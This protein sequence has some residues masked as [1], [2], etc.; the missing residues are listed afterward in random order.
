LRGRVLVV[1][2]DAV[3][4]RVVDMMLRRLGLETKLVNNGLEAV[5]LASH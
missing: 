4:L 1:D 2:N 5:G 3:N